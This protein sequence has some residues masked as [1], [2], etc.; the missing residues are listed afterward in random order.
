MLEKILNY[1]KLDSQLN[2]CERDLEN[3]EAKKTVNNMIKYV[4]TS[5]NKLHSIESEAEE[6]FGA[7]EKLNQEYESCLK[8]INA[9]IKKD[10]SKLDEAQVKELADTINQV[11]NQI[12]ILE[13]RISAYADI[14]NNLLKNF[15]ATKNNIM[16]GRQKYSKSK[17][18]YDKKVAEC[19][20]KIEK[21]KKELTVLEKDIEKPI[22]A[23]YKQLK[24]DNIFPVFVPL[25]LSTCG[26]CR[27]EQ[28]SAH[29]QKLKE[30]GY[31]ECEQC[32]RILYIL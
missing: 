30:K 4:K 21:I 24:Q 18:V 5:Q 15:E 6:Q 17:E 3:D 29:I 28:S 22:M 23:K 9:L 26:G 12:S 1:Q 7:F 11:N 27:M 32:H 8:T 25:S 31:I 10:T 19:S 2:A 20:P 16:V 13:R 14:V